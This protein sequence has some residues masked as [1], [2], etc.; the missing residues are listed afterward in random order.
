M[1]SLS[2]I[3]SPPRKRR[4]SARCS[5]KGCPSVAGRQQHRGVRFNKLPLNKTTRQYWFT[6][7]GISDP[8]SL[9]RKFLV[10]S[11]HFHRADFQHLKKNKYLLKEGAVPT[12]FPWG[13]LSYVEPTPHTVIKTDQPIIHKDNDQ[14]G[15]INEQL[16]HEMVGIESASVS[17]DDTG[18]SEAKVSTFP[19]VT[20]S[21]FSLG[22][23][24]KVQGLDGFWHSAKV[25]EV[26]DLE[27]EV[28]LQ[29][30][31]TIKSEVPE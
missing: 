11:R 13:T 2:Q 23:C 8:K 12:I 15:E 21:Q 3:M 25:M 22:T 20:A 28:F 14:P 7:C 4:R 10:C 5:I 19:V 30:E 31:K 26:D 27:K 6:N 29:F 18:T 9:L 16:V 1:D 17:V 24:I